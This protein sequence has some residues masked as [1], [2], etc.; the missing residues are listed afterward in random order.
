MKKKLLGIF[1]C[2]LVIVSISS[3][4]GL[5]TANRN[6]RGEPPLLNN[7]LDSIPFWDPN[8]TVSLHI[9]K[10]YV[11]DSGDRNTH[12][13][14]ELFF[15]IY[16][17]PKFWL[18]ITDIFLVDDET[19]EVPYDLGKLGAFSTKFTPQWILILALEDD[20]GEGPINFNDFLGWK[21]IKFKP[22]KGDY[23]HNDPYIEIIQWENQHF[24]AV[25]KVFFSYYSEP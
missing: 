13:P 15:R 7:D 12:D 1:V 16:S 17:I 19:P 5:K 14:A 24:R 2:V 10:I 9:D 20:E 23:P 11:Y 6:I 22:P 8:H 21:L 3:V 25:V 4:T 18:F